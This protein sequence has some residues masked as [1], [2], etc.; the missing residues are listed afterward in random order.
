MVVSWIL[1]ALDFVE[2]F[3]RYRSVVSDQPT[4][5]EGTLGFRNNVV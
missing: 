2:A 4:G 3:K 5:D 1:T